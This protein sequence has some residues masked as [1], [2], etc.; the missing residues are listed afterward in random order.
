M[1]L[2]LTRNETPVNTTNVDTVQRH[3]AMSQPQKDAACRY[4]VTIPPIPRYLNTM[5]HTSIPIPPMS[6]RHITTRQC[7]NHS[8][9]INAISIPNAYQSN[10]PHVNA[11]NV[12]DASI[13]TATRHSTP[14]SSTWFLYPHDV[15]RDNPNM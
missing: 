11:T 7:R 9:N 13:T 6:I 4:P 12:N 5:R 2:I 15:A 3:M 8:D 14:I 10:E 1:P